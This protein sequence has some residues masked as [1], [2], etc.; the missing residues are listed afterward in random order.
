MDKQ[1]GSESERV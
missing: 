1:R